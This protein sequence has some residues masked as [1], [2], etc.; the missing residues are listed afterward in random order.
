MLYTF[1]CEMPRL[2]DFI[3]KN[4]FKDLPD[5]IQKEYDSINSKWE[6]EYMFAKFGPSNTKPNVSFIG[7]YGKTPDDKTI[8]KNVYDFIVKKLKSLHIEFHKI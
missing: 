4:L 8:P 3:F 6:I 5:D 7:L 2:S 1:E